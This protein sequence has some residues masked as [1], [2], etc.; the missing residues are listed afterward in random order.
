MLV[1]QFI[2]DATYICTVVVQLNSCRF[3][4]CVCVNVYS[5]EDGAIQKFLSGHVVLP[6]YMYICCLVAHFKKLSEIPPRYDIC[7]VVVLLHSC[8]VY[9]W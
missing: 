6:S 2:C 7:T 4:L 1:A 3:Y 8:R 5:G 9:L